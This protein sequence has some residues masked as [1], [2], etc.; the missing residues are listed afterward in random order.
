MLFCFWV[1]ARLLTELSV[2]LSSN[3]NF[4]TCISK[5]FGQITFMIY[6]CNHFRVNYCLV[7]SGA[8]T[9]PERP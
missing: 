4:P 2:H 8:V 9:A 3:I 5:K 7:Y 6:K 1:Q